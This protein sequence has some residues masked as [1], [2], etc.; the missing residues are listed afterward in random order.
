MVFVKTIG[1]VVGACNDDVPVA[2]DP[3]CAR[4]MVEER[5]RVLRNVRFNIVAL[6]VRQLA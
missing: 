6:Q 1:S 3:L 2:V 5:N 4:A